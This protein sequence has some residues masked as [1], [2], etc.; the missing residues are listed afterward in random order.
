[1]RNDAEIESTFYNLLKNCFL[2]I[3]SK[4]IKDLST[5]K[6]LYTRIQF[7][8]QANR[9]DS[10]EKQNKIRNITNSLLYHQMQEKTKKYLMCLL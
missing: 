4:I 8:N 10:E 9:V 7:I 6:G 3:S 2:H 1:M 5:N